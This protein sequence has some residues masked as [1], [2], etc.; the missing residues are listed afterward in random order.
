MPVSF[1]ATGFPSLPSSKRRGLWRANLPWKDRNLHIERLISI[2]IWLLWRTKRRQS[3]LTMGQRFVSL[4]MAIQRWERLERIVVSRFD[5]CPV[6]IGHCTGTKSSPLKQ[7]TPTIIACP[8]GWQDLTTH[9]R[10]FTSKDCSSAGIS[11]ITSVFGTVTN[12]RNG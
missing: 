4:L 9:L 12:S 11:S 7:N 5:Q 2:M 3:C 1:K 6:L 10:H 8:S